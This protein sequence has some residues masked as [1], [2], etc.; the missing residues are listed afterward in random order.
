MTK[1]FDPSNTDPAAPP[2]APA[3][4]FSR[5]IE[6]ATL[7]AGGIEREIEAEPAEREALARRFDLVALVALRAGIQIIPIR[8]GA[9]T[10]AQVT[11]SL[12][13]RV[14]QTCVVSLDPFETEVTESFRL[15]LL[16]SD[17]LDDAGEAGLYHDDEVEPLEGDVL[18][19]GELVAQYLSLALDPHPRRPGISFETAGEAPRKS[20]EIGGS[21]PFAVLGDLRRKM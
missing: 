10:G 14:T 13:A 18:D 19:I 3:A 6:L 20:G 15:D 4:E 8:S 1:K 12:T 11:G 2:E 21:G 9:A 7:P 17:V 5:L 16:P